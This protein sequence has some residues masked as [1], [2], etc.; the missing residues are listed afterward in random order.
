MKVTG[1]AVVI[2]NMIMIR[3][4][5]PIDESARVVKWR[6]KSLYSY[7]L[8]NCGIVFF[9]IWI[10]YTGGD[11]LRNDPVKRQKMVKLP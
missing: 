11:I 10:W 1:Y 4:L 7:C 9:D 2:C 3:F 6:I 8:R 5:S